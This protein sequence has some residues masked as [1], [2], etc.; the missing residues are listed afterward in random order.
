MDPWLVI[1]DFNVVMGT[2]ETSGFL[3]SI[4][5]DDFRAGVTI[6]NLIDLDT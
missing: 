4:S 3:R 1:N 2:H 5:Y 6:C